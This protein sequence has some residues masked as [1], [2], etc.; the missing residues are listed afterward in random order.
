[1]RSGPVA[2]VVVCA[3][4]GALVGVLRGELVELV[5]LRVV[6]NLLYSHV[7]INERT[8]VP[9]SI[10]QTTMMLLV[11]ASSVALS[12][13]PIFAKMWGARRPRGGG[14]R[15]PLWKPVFSLVLFVSF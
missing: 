6:E 3:L 1:M 10:E 5:S 9:I 14:V 12:T 2:N 15:I 7:T 11:A 13:L 4:A 8:V